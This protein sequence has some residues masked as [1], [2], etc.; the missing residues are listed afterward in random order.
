MNYE[1]THQTNPMAPGDPL[2]TLLIPWHPLATPQSTPST[3]K[4]VSWSHGTL[5]ITS[6]ASQITFTFIPVT[7]VTPN[8]LSP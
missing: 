5:K 4:Q 7:P 2:D 8:P 6:T 1:K 3:H